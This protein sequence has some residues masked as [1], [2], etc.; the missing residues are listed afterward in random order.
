MLSGLS[1]IR[2]D[3]MPPFQEV[4]ISSSPFKL[5]YT[6]ALSSILIRSD[7]NMVFDKH[8]F[9]GLD[10]QAALHSSCPYHT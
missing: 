2:E 4:V 8:S 10:S 6:R 9:L 1:S 7:T 3:T 5:S